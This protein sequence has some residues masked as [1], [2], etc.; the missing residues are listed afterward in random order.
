MLNEGSFR[1]EKEIQDI[2]R[3]LDVDE[4]GTDLRIMQKATKVFPQWP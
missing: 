4:I 3:N 2:L 1:Y